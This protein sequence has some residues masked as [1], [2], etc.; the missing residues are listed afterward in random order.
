LEDDVSCSGEVNFEPDYQ[1]YLLTNFATKQEVEQDG[2][3]KEGR[4]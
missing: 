4:I 1:I 2:G 3:G